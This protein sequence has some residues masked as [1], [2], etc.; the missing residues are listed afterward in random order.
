[1]KK[2]LTFLGIET[3][4][5]ET[6]ASIV[7][8][9]KDGSVK[10]LSNVVSSQVDEHLKFGGVV[11]ENA[12][13]S[14]AE[15]I[16][17]IIKKAIDDSKYKFEELDGVAATAGPGLLVCL[18]VGLS[19]GKSI[20]GILKK[21]F[22]AINHL[23][24]HAL[25]ARIFNKI[26]FPY[27]LLLVSGG[28]TQFLI[29]EDIGKYKR[30]GTT[31]D[32]ALGETFDKTAKMIGLEFPGGPK[33]EKLAKHG[34]ERTYV[35]PK[36]ILNHPGCN[37]SFAG[38]KT[39][40]LNLLPKIKTDKDK[41]NL[42]AS[43]QKTINEILYSKCKVAM[44]E[45]SSKYKKAKKVFVISGGVAANHSIRKNL[46]KLSK[47]MDFENLFP[48][49]ELCSDNGAMIAWAGIERFKSGIE[50]NL[51]VLAKPRWP[52]DPEAPF[53]KGAGVKY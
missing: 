6:A 12:A 17:L 40:I 34:D 37:L 4:C 38:L 45:F 15:K 10:I 8:E 22:L 42:A 51:E 31:I 43:F 7:R 1:M 49:A 52:L 41:E 3:S 9:E 33:L 14:H 21:P 44:N 19:A 24:G 36:P 16:D 46:E 53:L 39:S 26:N 20:A 29:V 11:P 18:M 47:E 13:R 50:D 5:D 30:I 35:L 27:L 28:H 23:E 2:D 25:T 48:P 32:D